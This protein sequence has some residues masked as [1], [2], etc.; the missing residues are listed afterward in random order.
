[1]VV[2]ILMKAFAAKDGS[3]LVLKT[4]ASLCSFSLFAEFE[5]FQFYCDIVIPH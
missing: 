1:M 5:Q 3:K 4:P 2:W